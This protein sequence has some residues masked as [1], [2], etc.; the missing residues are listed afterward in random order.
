MTRKCLFHVW[1]PNCRSVSLQ[2]AG[3][4]KQMAESG[5]GWWE[6]SVAVEPGAEYAFVPD[7]G[8][9][10]P[11][12]RSHWQ[13]HGV[14]GLSRV[15]DHAAFPWT[16]AGW[17]ASPLSSAILYELHIGTF[18]P[19]GTFDSAIE[20]LG[21]LVD[22]GVTHVELMP[23][24]EFPGAWGWGYD[25]VDL[26]APHHGYGGPDGLK[27]FVDACHQ[28]RLA[29]ILDV[30][31]NHLGPTGNY[32]ERFGPY[33]TRRHA[34]PW[35]P[36]MNLDGAGSDQV[37]RFLCDNAL[38]WLREYHIDGL[39]IDAVHAL[40]DN[41]AVHFL[42]QLAREVRLLEA[43]LGRHLITIAESDL[44]N[45]RLVR[46]PE[47]GGYGLDAQWNDDFH[48]ALHTVLTGERN[49]YYTDFGSL[50]QLAKSLSK[51][52]V[53]DGCYSRFRGCRHGRPVE[54]L[55]GHRFVAFL[56]NH[57]QIG[58]RAR[59]ERIGHLTTRGR[60]FIGAT[61][62]LTSPFVPLLFQGEEWGASSPFQY[63]TSHEDAELARAVSEGRRNE[64]IAFG[65]PPDSVP[66]PQD[67]QTFERSK[68]L[69]EEIGEADHAELFDWYRKLIR[70]R[71]QYPELTDG[72][73]PNVRVSFD[74]RENWLEV[75]RGRIT[76]LCNFGNWRRRDLKADSEILLA[77]AHGAH[78][79]GR[80]LTLPP[81]SVAILFENKKEQARPDRPASVEQLAIS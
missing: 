57:D 53:Y 1:A 12:P 80:E 6:V 31:Y 75:R 43:Q 55:S 35:G 20:R 37:R 22:L 47:V 71:R 68:L 18:T 36:A 67:P 13:P 4:S 8:P 73:F 33:F 48:H 64:F 46:V 40:F 42:E 29:V 34:T 16:D 19:E 77:S 81:D 78:F 28:H 70:L 58:N 11:D 76:V 17:C 69:W 45:P 5:G 27:R 41:S 23:V 38:H 60:L 7:G 32:L 52:F 3:Q 74:E 49:G 39:R 26:Y 66:D 51:A 15:V 56:Q 9:P 10:V 50:A 79:S 61:L 63:F 54:G 2:L 14:H 24:A 25:G 59:G 72:C 65:W 30:V 44:N 21:H 62:L